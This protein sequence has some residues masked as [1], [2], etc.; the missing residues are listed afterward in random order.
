VVASAWDGYR[1]TVRD[2]VEGFLIPTLLGGGTGGLGP[3]LVERHLFEMTSY[4]AYAGA[5]AQH[6]A[7]HIGRCAQALAELI[8]DPQLRRRMGAAGRARVAGAYDW[9]VVARQ[10]RA[11]TDE[12]A[13]IRAQAFDPPAAA[14]AD[15][16]RGDPFR[17]FEGFATQALGLDTMLAPAPGATAEAV[18]ASAG[19]VL[20]VAF[21]ALR[22]DPTLCAEAFGVIEAAGRIAL[23]DV[24]LAFPTPQRRG[25]E[26]GV[27]WLAKYGFVDWLT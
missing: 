26:L 7:V 18:I 3:G 1:A 21:P 4:Q 17:A 11:L 12:L 16:V 13:E 10:V 9:A 14:A 6:T 24:L 15:P 20:D 22:A 25:L 27:A 2:G 23:R 19:T 5:V 8:G